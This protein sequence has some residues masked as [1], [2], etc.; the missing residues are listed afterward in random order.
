MCR[1][2]LRFYDS[3]LEPP[4]TNLFALGSCQRLFLH[5][6]LPRS[7]TR[8][9][10]MDA[11]TIAQRDVYDLWKYFDV[12]DTHQVMGAARESEIR[13][14]YYL[15]HANERMPFVPPVGINAGVLLLRLDRLTTLFDREVRLAYERYGPLLFVGDQDVLNIILHK[16]SEWLYV[17]P[18]EWNI[19]EDSW[20]RMQHARQMG[21]LHGNRGV[22]SPRREQHWLNPFA[23]TMVSHPFAGA[24]LWTFQ[25]VS[26][27][28]RSSSS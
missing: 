15:R 23:Q 18:C 14:G 19:R 28:L 11:D 7:V 1:L 25:Y 3:N 24:H 27:P 8:V 4:W 21:I 26:D 12:W 6:L 10:Y 22:F 13:D 20:C 9:L 2:D 17:L 16:R 5:H